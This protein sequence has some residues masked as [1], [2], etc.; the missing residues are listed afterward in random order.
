MGA[1]HF[2]STFPMIYENVANTGP[3]PAKPSVTHL[4]ELFVP[5]SYYCC[6]TVVVL[7]N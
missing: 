7:Q 3:H 2:P 5:S 6:T 1:V 4:E